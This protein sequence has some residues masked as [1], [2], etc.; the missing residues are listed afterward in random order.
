[1]FLQYLVEFIGS[2]IMVYVLLKTK[3]V[4]A[5][6]A[7][8]FLLIILTNK[9]SG[10]FFNP[11]ITIALSMFDQISKTDMFFYVLA[12]VL[13]GVIGLEIYKQVDPSSGVE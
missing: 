7:I 8:Y 3:N 10:G 4:L 5:V 12:Q 9:F 13:G 1:M 2:V 11:A 6:G